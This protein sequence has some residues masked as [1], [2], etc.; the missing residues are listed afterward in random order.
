[1]MTRI[2]FPLQKTLTITCI[3]SNPNPRIDFKIVLQMLAFNLVCMAWHLRGD[4]AELLV[5]NQPW[6]TLRSASE[7]KLVLPGPSSKHA[8]TEPSATVHPNCEIVYP[9]PAPL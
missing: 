1:M 3:S 7:N 5:Q 6:M 4:L 2:K 9:L 8:G